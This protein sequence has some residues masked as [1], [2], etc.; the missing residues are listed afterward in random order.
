MRGA[1]FCVAH[2][3]YLI[4]LRFLAFALQKSIVEM[5]IADFCQKKIAVALTNMLASAA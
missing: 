2:L 3:S 1:F 5:R 4:R